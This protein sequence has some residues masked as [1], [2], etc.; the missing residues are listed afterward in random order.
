MTLHSRNLSGREAACEDCMVL[1][2]WTLD[3]GRRSRPEHLDRPFSERIVRRILESLS[4]S[5]FVCKGKMYSRAIPPG[6]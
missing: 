4:S 3:H 2:F 5:S 6:A 1:F